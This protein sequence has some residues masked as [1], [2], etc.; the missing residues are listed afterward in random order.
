MPLKDTM[1][2]FIV[3]GKNSKLSEEISKYFNIKQKGIYIDKG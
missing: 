3:K 1:S 2:L